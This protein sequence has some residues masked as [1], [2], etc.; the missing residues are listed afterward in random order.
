MDIFRTF[1]NHSAFD[2]ST[3]VGK[4]PELERILH[5]FAIHNPNIGYCQSMNFVVGFLLLHMNEEDAFWMLLTIIETILPHDYFTNNIA[6]AYADQHVFLHI[7]EKYLPRI[8]KAMIKSGLDEQMP[9]IG[10]KWFMCLFVDTLPPY[11]V[12]RVWD[13]L[14][15]EG[16]IILFKVGAAILK[17]FEKEIL[18]SNTLQMFHSVSSLGNRIIEPDR[19]FKIVFDGFDGFNELNQ[20]TTKSNG[21]AT[22]TADNLLR[23]VP[24]ML[25]GIGVAHIG[26]LDPFASMRYNRMK[27]DRDRIDSLQTQRDEE[28]GNAL[29]VKLAKLLKLHEDKNGEVDWGEILETTRFTNDSQRSLGSLGRISSQS[30]HL[31]GTDFEEERDSKVE[32]NEN[33]DETLD[34]ESLSETTH[35][36]GKFDGSIS[37]AY[38]NEDLERIRKNCGTQMLFEER[39]KL[40]TN[41]LDNHEN[42]NMLF[43]FTDSD[44]SRWREFVIAKLREESISLQSSRKTN[45]SLKLDD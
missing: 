17:Y 15:N 35:F 31:E 42:R 2:K 23:L 26:P 13:L 38:S 20:K 25:Q 40:V 14:L 8:Y 30:K 32:N 28:D 36:E 22:L 41:Q 3:G 4:L 29:R 34:N 37:F 16:S 33:T 19:F 43:N 12:Q 39:R 24:P 1:P 11:I 7:I 21:Y 45:I 18:Q 10:I 5:T 6:G 44:I 9:L 27:E